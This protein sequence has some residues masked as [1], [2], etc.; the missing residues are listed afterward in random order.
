MARHQA[1]RRFG[2][3]SRGFCRVAIRRK[4]ARVGLR[5]TDARLVGRGNE[6]VWSMQE[7]LPV[8]DDVELRL[9]EEV[10]AERSVP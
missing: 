2:L 9:L 7:Q 10:D 1:E 4:E 8:A 3:S 5:G 6:Y